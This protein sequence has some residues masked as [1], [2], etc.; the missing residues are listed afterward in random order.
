MSVNTKE[1][2]KPERL[3]S[4]ALAAHPDPGTDGEKPTGTN[5]LQTRFVEQAGRTELITGFEPLVNS[6][7]SPQDEARTDQTKQFEV[8]FHLDQTN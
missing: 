3:D 1:S 7:G 6:T 2:P 8:S 4:A 5:F